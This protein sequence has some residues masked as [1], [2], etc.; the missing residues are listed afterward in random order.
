MVS[1]ARLRFDGSLKD[2][3]ATTDDARA[4]GGV[5]H[6]HL[7]PRGVRIARQMAGIQMHLAVPIHRYQG[8]LLCCDETAEPHLYRIV[9][10]HPDPELTIE[11]ARAPE[12]PAVLALWRSWAAYLG[13]PALYQEP[14]SPDAAWPDAIACR[15]PR[16]RGESLSKRRPCHFKRGAR[17]RSR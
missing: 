12:S 3:A 5:R 15:R 7:S 16:R 14:A 6:V 2:F 10:L 4:D 8:I 1:F 11:L 9:L 17:S 13:K